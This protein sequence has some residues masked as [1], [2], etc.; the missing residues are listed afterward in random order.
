MS[1]KSLLMTAVPAKSGAGFCTWAA[2]KRDE[3]K[4]FRDQGWQV[5]KQKKYFFNLLEKNFKLTWKL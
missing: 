3:A 4:M 2:S 1:L 5:D